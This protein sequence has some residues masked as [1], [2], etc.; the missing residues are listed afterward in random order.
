MEVK[1][2]NKKVLGIALASI[3]LAMLVAPAIAGKGQ[4]KLSFELVLVGTMG[5]PGEIIATGQAMH[6]NDVPFLAT[7]WTGIPDTEWDES[8][9]P[10]ALTIDGVPVDP[11][12]L[13]Y[14]GMMKVQYS[15]APD[16]ESG[17]PNMAIMVDETIT[18]TG[19]NAGTLVLQ[20]KGNNENTGNGEKAG[21]GDNF[22]GFG[23]GDYA[24][25][26]IQGSSPGG[27]VTV[28]E[29]G[30]ATFSKLVRVGTVMGWP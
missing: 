3:F 22:I 5:M 2:M 17:Q 7:G 8:Y 23:T 13:S 27:P 9:A 15:A 28:G 10:I 25:V 26:K 16:G 19:D 29:D 1:I 14:E 20:V 21:A 12:T 4:T 11:A 6:L 18:I 24:G 30:G